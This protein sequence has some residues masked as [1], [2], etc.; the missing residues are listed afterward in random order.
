MPYATMT[1]QGDERISFPR[2]GDRIPM[3]PDHVE[4]ALL[5]DSNGHDIV[6]GRDE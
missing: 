2:L 3:N 5:T 6:I 1:D 4:P